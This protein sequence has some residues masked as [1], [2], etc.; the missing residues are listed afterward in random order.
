MTNEFLTAPRGWIC[1]ICNRVYSPTTSMCYYCGGEQK[2]ITY[3]TGTG[4]IETEKT[5]DLAQRIGE[6]HD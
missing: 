1:P 3:T 2:T 4:I 5:K 6:Y